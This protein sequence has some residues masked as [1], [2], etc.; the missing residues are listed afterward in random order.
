MQLLLR[1]KSDLARGELI[2]EALDERLT[3]TVNQLT[4]IKEELETMVSQLKEASLVQ[5]Q[6]NN[7]NICNSN[8]ETSRNQRLDNRYQKKTDTDRKRRER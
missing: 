1:E 8:K 5:R 6:G 4:E 2:S 3:P 7:S